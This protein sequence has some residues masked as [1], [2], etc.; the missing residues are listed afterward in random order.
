VSFAG[1]TRRC[2]SIEDADVTKLKHSHLRKSPLG[3]T[4]NFAGASLRSI[5]PSE[6]QDGTIAGAPDS[7]HGE[8]SEAAPFPTRS[9][10]GINVS[11]C[12]REE[13]IEF[14]LA[15]LADRKLT[16]LAFANIHLLN[17]AS[18]LVSPGK[19][20]DFLVLNDGIGL[21]LASLILH[22]SRFPDN[23]NG[24]DL[25]P[26]LLRAA[27]PKTRVFLYGAI[28]SIVER[29]APVISAQCHVNICGFCD[30]YGVAV[31][32]ESVPDKIRQ[33]AP[34]IV[35][36]AL[37]NPKQEAWIAEHAAKLNVPLVIGVGAFFD[38]LAGAYPRAPRWV[39][40][41][42]LEWM[43][44]LALEPARLWR[45]YTV[46]ALCLYVRLLRARIRRKGA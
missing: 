32:P 13:A 42:R 24:T 15:R 22:G 20:D 33:S 23:L 8:G 16:R 46:D 29:V 36:V 14:L 10:L 9:F 5:L 27:G 25:V 30:G 28:P 43:Y 2:A 12:L 17:R 35:L 38:I 4:A 45:R 1:G 3:N 19:L 31:A 39:R 41:L 6:G 34:D 26:A 18:Q 40:R 7:P 11:A 21:D 44:R 37:G